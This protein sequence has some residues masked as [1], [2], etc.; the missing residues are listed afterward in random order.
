MRFC[1]ACGAPFPAAGG[2]AP[3]TEPPA[4]V[5]SSPATGDHPGTVAAYYPSAGDQAASA[6]P[7]SAAGCE[8]SGSDAGQDPFGDLFAPGSEESESPERSETMAA[9]GNGHGPA[10]HGY[11]YEPRGPIASPPPGGRGRAVIA[12][13]AAVGVLAAGGGAAF[14]LTHRH[15]ASNSAL[16]AQARPGGTG[17]QG[18]N[19]P[20]SPATPTPSPTPTSSGNLVIVAPGVA[21]E[22]DS[23]QVESYVIS[24]FTAINNHSYQ[25][26]RVLL[27]RKM[28]RDESVQE[29]YNGFHSTS[30]SNA[31]LS[32]ISDISPGRVGAALTFTSHQLPADSPSKTA[33]TDWSIT[34]YLRKQ[35]GRYVLGPAPPGYHA[36]YQA[37]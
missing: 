13:L 3:V 29:F 35:G 22:P 8:P 19:G 26:Y 11:R 36:V 17:S 32:A 12:V 25:Q 15:Q 4:S 31:V 34:L 6:R 23:S 5:P 16:S 37:C 28:R 33:C 21:Q 20:S 27:D 1:A 14:W 7:G 9:G 24:Y 2:E 10:D 18:L 30:D